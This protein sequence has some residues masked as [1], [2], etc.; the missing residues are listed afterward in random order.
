MVAEKSDR[1]ELLVIES[2]QRATTGFVSHRF[3]V[4]DLL[5]ALPRGA[6]WSSIPRK[7]DFWLVC[8]K[9]GWYFGVEN[10]LF[11]AREQF[12]AHVR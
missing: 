9:K 8:T 12:G 10:D 7:A 4:R 3:G 5:Y 2:V 6:L 1:P 11:R